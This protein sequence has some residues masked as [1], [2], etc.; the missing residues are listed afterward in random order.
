MN[1]P[2][3]PADTPGPR[4]RRSTGRRLRGAIA[5]RL[6]T[7]IVSGVYPP[8]TVLS[9]EVEFS[10]ALQVSRG[11]FREAMQV[12]AAKGL[13]ESRPKTGTRV[14]PRA[15]WNLLDP[16]VL[17]WAFAGEPD[18]EFVRSIFEL[19]AIVEPGAARLA[20]ERGTREDLSTMKQALAGMRRHSLATEPGQA[21][22]RDFHDAILRATRNDALIVLSSTIGA[23]VHWTTRYKQRGRT[24]P[25]NPMPDHVK[26]YD[27]IAAG[28]GDAA[29]AAM[30]VLVDLAMADTAAQM[31]RAGAAGA[32][33]VQP[34]SGPL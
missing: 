30:R 5:N 22:D 34:G 10:E 20:A 6:G 19:R 7:D 15:R 17:G 29:A 26:V 23:A 28:D 8:G 24:L 13:V 4:A 21:A 25:R 32:A 33:P 9:S 1:Q 14:L 3:S 12:L 31:Q 11:A 27:A 16:D 2:A 18:P